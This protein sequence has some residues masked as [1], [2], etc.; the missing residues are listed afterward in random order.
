MPVYNILC[1]DGMSETSR[2]A[3]SLS[4]AAW[5]GRLLLAAGTALC[6]AAA[7]CFFAWNWHKLADVVKFSLATGG[8]LLC[9][10]LSLAAER[11]NTPLPASLALL[12]SCMCIGMF[13]AVFGQIFQSGA[14][15]QDLCLVW[16]PACFP[17]SCSGARPAC[18]IY[19]RF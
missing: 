2:F 6:L 19:G 13:W 7:I 3:D 14:T 1:G 18:G 17:F 4:P 15:E 5:T 10:G 11:R 12:A 9:T 8:F 16:P